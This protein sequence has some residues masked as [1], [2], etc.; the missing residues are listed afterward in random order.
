MRRKKELRGTR[1][2][3]PDR[4]QQKNQQ[5]QLEPDQKQDPP[6]RKTEQYSKTSVIFAIN[7]NHEMPQTI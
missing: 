7:Q 4:I 1:L 2:G 5:G 6:S 3:V